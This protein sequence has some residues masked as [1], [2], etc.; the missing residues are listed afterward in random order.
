[1]FVL[2]LPALGRSKGFDIFFARAQE[3]QKI[4]PFDS[5]RLANAEENKVFG[6]RL[7]RR[8]SLEQF[9]CPR[10]CL[11]GMFSIIVIPGHA[12][13][14]QK[15]EESLPACFEAPL[16]PDCR[17]AAVFSKRQVFVKAIHGF[18]VLVQKAPF[19]PVAIN[20]FDHGLK[21]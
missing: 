5:A 3:I 21:K 8:G 13:V 16:A 11:D 4:D 2:P 15:C 6:N 9:S 18:H 20:R 14:P 19:Q 12:I 7:G 17:L 10:I 1:M